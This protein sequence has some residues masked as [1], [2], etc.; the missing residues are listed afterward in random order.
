MSCKE[1]GQPFAGI[2]PDAPLHVKWYPGYIDDDDLDVP[3]EENR[4]W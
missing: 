1:E 3:E 4:D 2:A